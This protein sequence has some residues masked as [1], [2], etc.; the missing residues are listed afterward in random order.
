MDFEFGESEASKA[1]FSEHPNFPSAFQTL[2][3]VSNRCFGRSFQFNNQA[4]EIMFSL[5]KTCRK[6]YLEI[7]F[8]GVHGF[9]VA[10][11]KL[12]RGLYERE[13]THAHIIKNPEKVMKFIRFGAVQEYRVMKGALEAG[14]TEEAF[15]KQMPPDYS[16]A[17][18]TERR[19]Q[20]VDEFKVEECGTCGMEAPMS[21][22]KLS[23]GAMARKAGPI[24]KALYL[25]G[26]AMPNLHIHATLTS[27]M[28]LDRADEMMASTASKHEAYFNMG[29]ASIIMLLVLEEQNDLFKLGLEQELAAAEK[30]IAEEFKI[31]SKPESSG[32]LP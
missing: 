25:G 18:I 7:V 4:E 6:D 19:D 14:V 1:F 24:H 3:N 9:H 21:W 12:L 31:P 27:A 8:M 2:M 29:Q 16:I 32:A 13:V 23:P 26:Y 17:K 22:D 10:T 28:C 11:T 5:G 30:A 20:V 15:N